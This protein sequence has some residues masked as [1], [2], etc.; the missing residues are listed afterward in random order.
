MRSDVQAAKDDAARA[1]QRLDTGL[2]LTVSKS[3]GNKMAHSVRH[4]APQHEGYWV[5]RP[6]S[7][8][9]FCADSDVAVLPAPADTTTGYPAL[10]DIAFSTAGHPLLYPLR[11]R[12]TPLAAWRWSGCFPFG[13]RKRPVDFDIAFTIRLDGKLYRLIDNPYR[14]PGFHG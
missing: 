1:N 3:S 7:D 10:L 4:F 6:L 12:E 13:L 5:S 9:L 14:R 11:R 8:E 2:T